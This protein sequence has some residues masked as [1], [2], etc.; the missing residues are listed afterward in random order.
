MTNSP[1]PT[2]FYSRF[3][4]H[5]VVLLQEYRD[6]VEKSGVKTSCIDNILDQVPP[7]ITEVPALVVP[8]EKRV[9]F[10]NGIRTALNEIISRSSVVEMNVNP[11]EAQCNTG[12]VFSFL[13]GPHLDE[14]ATEENRIDDNFASPFGSSTVF[15]SLSEPED[16]TPSEK[17]SATSLSSL[18]AKRAAD[19]AEVIS[20]QPRPIVT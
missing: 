3:C 2:L 9:Y 8:S 16:T 11:M 20:S 1:P 19:I 18:E 6:Q 15:G 14:T 4:K 10:W 12:E 5:C 17:I 7:I 13:N